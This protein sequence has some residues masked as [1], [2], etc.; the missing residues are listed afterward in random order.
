M[1]VHTVI[2]WLK[3]DLSDENKSTFFKEVATLG[4]I[5]SV[6]DFHLGTPAETPKR[7]VIDD[8]YDCAIT[9]V[10]KD[11]AAQDQYQIDPI[12]HQFIDKCS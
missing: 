10:L 9:V 11:L 1:L 12:H 3:N 6:E 8:S 2:F 5:S 7:P 4:T